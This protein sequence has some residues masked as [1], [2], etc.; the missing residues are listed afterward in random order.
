MSNSS[1]KMKT[2][3]ESII[4]KG[5][6]RRDFIKFTTYMTAFMGFEASMIGQVTKA[7]ETKKR[8]PVIWVHF[9]ECTGCSESFIRSDHPLVADL[10]LDHISLDYTETL[11]AASGHNA[12][13]AKQE[14]MKEN[15][16][17]YILVVEGAI[18]MKDD[19]VYCSIG[20]RT[21][22]DILKESA[23]G[24]AAILT[25]GSCSSWGGVQ[26]AHPNP[27]GSVPVD[28]IIKDKPIIRVPGCPPIAE[29]MT[30]VVMHYAT[31]GRLPELDSL[32]RPKQFYGKRVHDTCYRRPNFDAGLYAESFDSQEAKDGYCLYKLGCRGPVSY[33]AC[34]S[35]G[36]NNGV[37][38]PIKSGYPCIGCSEPDFWDNSP[39]TE[40]LMNIPGIGIESSADTIGKVTVGV[41][42]GAA[43]V[44]ALATNI[45]KKK[46]LREAEECGEEN[47][48][49]IKA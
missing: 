44:H 37:S 35:M 41:A 33:N 36:W 23:A 12:E 49:N 26:A 7:M 3:Y 15:Y 24:A 34:G 10:I 9:Q 32:G 8:I 38:F 19:G 42:A 21:A 45:A 30:G 5:Y 47:E 31:F 6:S 25:F 20:G 27:T 18:P 40:R 13:E 29:V 4:E 48:R 2:Y 11:M 22:I 46:E 39:F 16:G 43:V 1:K 28:A 14:S 17:N